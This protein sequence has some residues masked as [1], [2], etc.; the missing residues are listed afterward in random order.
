MI[1][2]AVLALLLSALPVAAALAGD[3]SDEDNKSALVTLTAVQKGSLPLTVTA[4]GKTMPPV[5]ARETITAPVASQLTQV[6]V[7]VGQRI[8]KGSPMAVLVA[9]PETRAEYRNAQLAV[10]LAQQLVARDQSLIRSHLQTQAELAKDENDLAGAKSKVEVLTEEGA[11]GPNTL[12]APFD[13]I[14]I[15][16]DAAAGAHVLRGDAL[17]ELARPNG[18][19]VEAGIQPAQAMQVKAGDPVELAPLTGG[20][21]VRGKVALRSEVVD[22]SDGL[23]PVD[24]AFP[25][26]KLLV[27]ETVR[28]T[29]TVGEVLGYIVPHEAILV[30]DDG[31]NFIWQAVKMAAKKVKV[32]V[33]GSDGDK[34]VIE[35]KLD[36]SAKV[37]LSGN[38]QLDDGTKLRLAEAKPEST[39]K[40][41]Q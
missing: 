32:K 21:G 2:S 33:L 38:H 1:R 11:I 20:E 30:D 41:G 25:P 8:A 9:S 18:L 27:G 15:K 12:R 22:Q 28:A 19:V 13:A 16:N 36:P 39:G 26:G 35:G 3:D 5:A 31:S 7:Q 40:A 4:F 29:I 37:V 34:D 24:V 6:Y 17:I 10:R 14:V 23:V